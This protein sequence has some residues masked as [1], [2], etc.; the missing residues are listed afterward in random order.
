LHSEIPFSGSAGSSTHANRRIGLLGGSFNPAHDGHRYISIEALKRLGLDEVWW[1][2]SP[3]NPLKSESGMAPFAQRLEY[4]R[5]IVRHPRIRVSAIEAEMGT[6][7][8]ANTLESLVQRYPAAKFVWLMGADNLVQISA[9]RDWSKIFR[10][11]SIAVFAR[12]SYDSK[13]LSAR[14]ASC[15]RFAQLPASTAGR[16]AD[17]APPAWLFLRIRPHPATET[18]LRQAGAWPVET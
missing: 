18:D 3:Q 11:V 13:A 1:L 14:A 7:Y 10:T 15:F 5:Q 6:R 8:T 4:A 2:V 12:D 16:L 17:A 9:W